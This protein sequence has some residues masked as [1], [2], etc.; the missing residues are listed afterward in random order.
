M[1][2]RKSKLNNHFLMIH[3]II[4]ILD[5]L[6]IYCNYILCFANCYCI[7]FYHLLFENNHKV[8][9]E[10]DY[11]RQAFIHDY[12]KSVFNYISNCKFTMEFIEIKKKITV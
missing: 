2:K 6:I 12:I 4:I 9:K 7:L 8:S 11:N 1:D 10:N 5:A 3:R